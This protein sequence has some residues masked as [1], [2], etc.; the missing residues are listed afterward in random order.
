MHPRSGVVLSSRGG[1]LHRLLPVARLDVL[2]RFGPGTQVMSWISLSDEVAAI[3][4]L[5]DHGDLSGPVNLTA[6]D[7]VTDAAFTAALDHALHRPD[8]PW[9]RAPAWLLRAALGEGASASC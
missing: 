8:M 4:F 5:L 7:P 1:L 2:P 6:P 9:W 3:R